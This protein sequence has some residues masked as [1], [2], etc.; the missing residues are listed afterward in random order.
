[1]KRRF[2]LTRSTDFERVRRAGKSY[3]HPLVVL[4]ALRSEGDQVR[5]GVS[6]GRSVGSA[7]ERNRAKRVLRAILAEFIPRLACGWDLI[8]LARQGLVN[9][10]FGEA[11]GAVELLLNRAHLFNSPL[12]RE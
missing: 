11:R 3:A 2:R 12:G 7:V 5:V 9:A 8:F 4:V 10:P 1:V 6:A